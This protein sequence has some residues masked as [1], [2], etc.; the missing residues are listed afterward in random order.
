MAN[1]RS[2][3]RDIK[4]SR[5]RAAR[6]QSVRSAIKT[7]MKKSRTA[8]AAGEENAM[9]VLSSTSALVDKAAKRGIIHKNAANRR[10]SRLAQRLNAAQAQSG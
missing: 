6:N 8:I 3:L 4:K 9:E 2:A 5:K 1:L 7:W 10:K